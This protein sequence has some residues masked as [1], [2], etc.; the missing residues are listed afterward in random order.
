MIRRISALQPG[1]ALLWLLFAPLSLA[2]GNAFSTVAPESVGVSSEGLE[3]LNEALQRYVDDERL[4]GSVTLVARRGG[5]VYHEAFGQ[6]DREARAPM[7][8]DTMFRIASQTKAIVS[9]AAMTLVEDGRLLLTDPVSRWLP[10][11]AS[12]TV[13]VPREDGEGYDVVP[14]SRPITVRD[15]LMHTSGFDYGTGIAA[16]RWR[17]AGIQNWY[18]ADRDEPIGATVARM[19]ALPAAAHPGQRWIYG[20]NTDILGALIERVAGEPLDAFLERRIF[21]PLAMNDTHF[22]PPA[23]KRDRVAGVYA[24][25]NGQLVRAPEQ[26]SAAQGAYLDGPKR[27]FSG[28]AGL[29]STAGDYG[30]FLQMLLNGG[31]LDGARVLGRKTVELMTVNHLGDIPFNPGQGFGLGF[32][33]VEDLGARGLPGSV[34]E[35]GWGGAYHSTYWVDPAEQLLV[36]HLTQLIPATG[37]DDFERVRTL[38]Y[39]A[40]MD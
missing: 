40:L 20:Y 7:R 12:T 6:R 11:F 4:A 17:E 8:E 37:V 2:D 9:V 27:S 28:G 33:V 15:L 34:G 38:V 13:A 5:I 25:Q 10:E 23:A 39:A 30:R 18:F 35:F 26:G 14:A 29:V 16:D 1:L 19:A 3:R 31:E 36:V 24:M 21:A 32:S 22:Y